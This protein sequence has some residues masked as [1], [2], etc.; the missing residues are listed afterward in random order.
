MFAYEENKSLLLG[1]VTHPFPPANKRRNLEKSHKI[2]SQRITTTVVTSGQLLTTLSETEIVL[3]S[4]CSKLTVRMPFE[5]AALKQND[6][7]SNQAERER[8][9]CSGRAQNYAY[10]LPVLLRAGCLNSGGSYSLNHVFDAIF[11]YFFQ[12]RTRW[13]RVPPPHTCLEL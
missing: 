13:G 11:S 3:D 8:A 7:S 6:E 9:H 12:V 4:P 10:S 1:H 2:L 5:E